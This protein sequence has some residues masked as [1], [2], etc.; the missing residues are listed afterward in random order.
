MPV[1]LP[2]SKEAVPLEDFKIRPICYIQLEEPRDL[3]RGLVPLPPLLL[4]APPTVSI[5]MD[6]QPSW[7]FFLPLL[8]R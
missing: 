7:R 1:A 5:R 2:C 6:F 3:S 4:L 8:N